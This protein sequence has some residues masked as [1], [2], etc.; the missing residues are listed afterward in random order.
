M[1]LSQ[2]R[3][4]IHYPNGITVTCDTW[5]WGQNAVEDVLESLRA[6]MRDDA[7][8]LQATVTIDELPS[9]TE[10]KPRREGGA[11]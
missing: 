9:E 8:K 3:V 2:F 5:T 6:A 1:G 4:T 10:E 11:A 7:I